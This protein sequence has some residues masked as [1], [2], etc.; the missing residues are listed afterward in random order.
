M[1]GAFNPHSFFVIGQQDLAFT[2]N[3]CLHMLIPTNGGSFDEAAMTLGYHGQT[4]TVTN[5]ICIKACS[6]PTGTFQH[7]DFT[8][9]F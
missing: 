1:Y 7:S 6:V 9:S 4:P 8:R 3:D 5:K 2:D